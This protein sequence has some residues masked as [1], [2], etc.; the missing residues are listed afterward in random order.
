MTGHDLGKGDSV[1]GGQGR[2]GKAFPTFLHGGSAKVGVGNGQ[3]L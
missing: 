3:S 1:E 2:G